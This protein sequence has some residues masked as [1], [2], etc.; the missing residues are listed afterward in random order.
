MGNADAGQQPGPIPEHLLKTK[1]EVDK[2]S[3]PA[4]EG[5]SITQH[6]D[7]AERPQVGSAT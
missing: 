3:K 2:A 4:A 1:A 5:G 6:R 7:M